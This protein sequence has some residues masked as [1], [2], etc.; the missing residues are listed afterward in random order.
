[1]LV[2]PETAGI[3]RDLAALFTLSS[4]ERPAGQPGFTATVLEPMWIPGRAYVLDIRVQKSRSIAGVQA[5][6]SLLV[7]QVGAQAAALLG[8]QRLAIVLRIGLYGT[9]NGFYVLSAEDLAAGRLPE[10]A[11]YSTDERDVVAWLQEYRKFLSDVAPLDAANGREEYVPGVGAYVALSPDVLSPA[12]A[13]ELGTCEDW[14]SLLLDEAVLG[15]GQIVA[16]RVRADEVLVVE[17]LL[18]T[19][20]DVQ[21]VIPAAEYSDV[22][23]WAI[24]VEE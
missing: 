6:V 23:G 21:F 9:P 19:Y 14:A 5:A 8:D 11:V 13:R 16:E 7:A 22:S 17:G 2:A 18:A 20:A 15:V 1:V 3:A 24:Y 10:Y 12:A 4:V